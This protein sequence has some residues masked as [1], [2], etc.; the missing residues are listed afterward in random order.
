MYNSIEDLKLIGLAQHEMAEKVLRNQIYKENNRNPTMLKNEKRLV[1]YE[2]IA[3]KNMT[4][5]N[6]MNRQYFL[7]S[8]DQMNPISDI[9]CIMIELKSQKQKNN[10]IEEEK[11]F[12]PYVGFVDL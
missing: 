4:R 11:F 5:I 10:E 9:N 3:K 8:G 1:E 2:I 7:K 12:V 6:A